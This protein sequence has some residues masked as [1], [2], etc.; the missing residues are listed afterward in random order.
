MG[1]FKNRYLFA[2]IAITSL[3]ACEKDDICEGEAATPNMRIEFYD[4]ANSTVLKSFFKVRCFAVPETPSDS[5]KYIEYMNRSEIQLPLNITSNQ[6]VWNITLF[7]IVNNDT[8]QKTDQITF[9]YNPKIEYVSK[10]CG[11][12][13]IFENVTA[14]LNENNPGNWITNFTLLTNNIINQETPDAKIYY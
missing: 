1:N 7:Q 4:K 8:I 9:T 11:Y 2:F 13:T 12:K 3:V 5:I 10:A 6:T 14:N